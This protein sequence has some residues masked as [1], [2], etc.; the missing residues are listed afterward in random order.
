MTPAASA[1]RSRIQAEALQEPL[2]ACAG[3]ELAPNVALAQLL[4]LAE[5]R[6]AAEA[7]LFRAGRQFRAAPAA[8]RLCAL[9]SLWRDT[10]RA[11]DTVKEVLRAADYCGMTA[12]SEE[13]ARRFDEAAQTSPEMGAA[14]YSLG[15]ADLFEATARSIVDRL[16]S[17]G[18]AARDRSAL[19]LGCGCGRLLAALSPHIR[20]I[21]GADVSQGMLAAAQRRCSAL[22]NVSLARTSGHDLAA[23]ADREFDLVL[24]VDVFP[25]LVGSAGGL[26]QRHLF[27]ACRVLVPGGSLLILNYSY[28]HD[29]AAAATEVTALGRLAGL[30]LVRIARN[31]FELW[32]GRT[33]HFKRPEV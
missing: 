23:F 9:N 8:Q 6:E 21:V 30:E 13:W 24:A 20:R 12:S 28:V 1:T 11:W 32:D 17:W 16:L 5:T 14:L 22:A 10:P 3:G 7:A 2:R 4:T 25:F 33:F 29:D 26:A 19:D 15:R 31:D 18:V 27:E